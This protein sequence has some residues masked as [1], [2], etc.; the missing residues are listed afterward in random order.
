MTNSIRHILFSIALLTANSA[1]GQV[2]VELREEVQTDHN[3]IQL[4]DIARV[5][6]ADQELR[7]QLNT[8][9]MGMLHADKPTLLIGRPRVAI[10]LRLAGLDA[11]EFQITGAVKS[12]VRR[13]T[14]Q[15]VTDSAIESAAVPTMEAALGVP[16]SHLRVRLNS[17]MMT[18]LPTHIQEETGLRV[19]VQ[20]PLNARIGTVSLTVRLWRDAQLVF[21]RS[22]RFDVFQKQHV[23]VTRTSLP[24]GHIIDARDV[25]F[26]DRFLATAADQLAESQVIGRQVRNALPAGKMIDL[27][28]LLA[29]PTPKQE[30]LVK[31][32]DSV[33]VTAISGSLRVKLTAAEAL[34]AGKA[35]DMIR[36]RNLKSNEIITGRVTG[37]GQ[38]E[39]RL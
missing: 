27:R 15:I 31:T 29:A 17:P 28:D 23:A 37:A 34:Q 10:R 1:F 7:Q 4:S 39:I 21:S 33:S 11:S 2:Q 14:P 5:H 30:Q 22:G 8:L 3:A 38:V 9:D 25:Q 18:T 36:I 32:R 24:R 26:T 6:V 19:E 35:G 12:V 13:R 16:A 20:S